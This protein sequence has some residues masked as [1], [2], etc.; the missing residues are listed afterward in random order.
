VNILL[1]RRCNRRCPY[2][3]AAAR[4]S[5][6]EAGASSSADEVIGDAAFDQALAFA[7]KS[8]LPVVGILGGEP[9]L[10]P[11]FVDLL[12]RAWGRGLETK[13]F[14]NGLWRAADVEAVRARHAAGPVPLRIVLNVNAPAITPPAERE[15]QRRLL[16]ALAP[17]C[18]LSYNVHDL[19]TD[20]TFL[21]DLVRAH[22]LGRHIRLG[23]AQPLAESVSR[24]LPVTEYQRV[25]PRIVA[26]ARACDAHDITV[27]F[28]CGFTLCMFTP[29]ELGILQL[30]GAP[31][32]AQCGPAVDVGTDLSVWACF[33]LA[34]VSPP[35]RLEQFE[36]LGA[37]TRHFERELGRLYRTGALDACIDCRYL[38]RRQCAG[39]CA[40]H[41]YRNAVA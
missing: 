16:E 25:A 9:S 32:Q 19:E 8:R 21:V 23:M 28:D 17:L 7:V 31:V 3:F 37:L 34:T 20:A 6:G 11:R 39:G 10:H 35:V 38:R 33:P 2:C 4:I 18:T 5:Y 30:A 26:L 15:A 14:T 36:D 27:G 40:A 29:E 13:V 22:G 12:A 1:T 24:H 41:V